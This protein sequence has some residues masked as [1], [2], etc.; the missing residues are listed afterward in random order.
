MGG[1]LGSLNM[2]IYSFILM[3]SII[4]ILLIAHRLFNTQRAEIGLWFAGSGILAVM[5]WIYTGGKHEM[6]TKVK[7][8]DVTSWDPYYL[9]MFAL[10]L[11]FMSAGTVTA[12][13]KKHKVAPYYTIL[14]LILAVMVGYTATYGGVPLEIWTPAFLMIL[15]VISAAV[16]VLGPIYGFLTKKFDIHAIWGALGWVVMLVGIFMIEGRFESQNFVAANKANM[17][18][19]AVTQFTAQL[20]DQQTILY[21]VFLVA[22]LLLF[23]EQVLTD[24]KFGKK[25]E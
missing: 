10:V 9:A 23:L 5:A 4:L 24:W 6:V 15:L 25:D 11:A 2:A 21:A 7:G 14:M 13:D 22:F 17:D 12:L 8:A 20:A 3:F 18:P 1:S 16:L 19:D